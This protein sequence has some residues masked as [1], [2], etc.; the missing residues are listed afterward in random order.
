MQNI[1][2]FPKMEINHSI[3]DG[4]LRMRFQTNVRIKRND[5]YYLI[6]ITDTYSHDKSELGLIDACNEMHYRFINECWLLFNFYK[7]TGA[8]MGMWNKPCEILDPNQED[9]KLPEFKTRT[10]FKDSQK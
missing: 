10:E 8:T 5:K 9:F 6:Y 3:I 7:I 1:P 2:T 4:N